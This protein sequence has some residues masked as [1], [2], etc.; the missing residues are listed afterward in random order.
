VCVY[1]RPRREL[2]LDGSNRLS[3]FRQRFRVVIVR[4]GRISSDCFCDRCLIRFD[5]RS[6]VYWAPATDDYYCDECSSVVTTLDAYL[7]GA[8]FDR[9]AMKAS[10]LRL[11]R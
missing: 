3:Q 1:F 5:S 6:L 11:V 9:P 8:V 10:H 7:G 2:L 4:K